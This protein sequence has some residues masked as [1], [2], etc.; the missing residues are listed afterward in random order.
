LPPPKISTTLAHILT[1]ERH[2]VLLNVI[3]LL[4]LLTI[5]VI[6]TAY[7]S[8]YEGTSERLAKLNAI[9]SASLTERLS[10]ADFVEL[11]SEQYAIVPGRGCLAGVGKH[12]RMILHINTARALER[13]SHLAATM[14][15]Q[16]GIVGCFHPL[17]AQRK[18]FEVT[19]EE[20]HRA[21]SGPRNH[22]RG[23]AVDVVLMDAT[24]R[25]MVEER[26]VLAGI[27]A[28]AGF[29]P[30][31]EGHFDLAVTNNASYDA[32]YPVKSDTRLRTGWGEA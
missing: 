28:T 27:M 25:T 31:T 10:S 11:D 13:A 16:L 12:G 18:L 17:E 6:S 19:G 20:R 24:N 22:C 5:L 30:G 32:Q 15:Y 2:A 23:T 29:L 14:G 21:D 9:G 26:F 4:L 1:E 8:D 3:V 7:C